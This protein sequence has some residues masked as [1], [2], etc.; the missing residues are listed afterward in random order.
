[1]KSV[2]YI[3][4]DNLETKKKSFVGFVCAPKRKKPNI[5]DI[6][7]TILEATQIPPKVVIKKNV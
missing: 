6:Y 5:L 7:Y 2:E 1:M 3:K 4:L